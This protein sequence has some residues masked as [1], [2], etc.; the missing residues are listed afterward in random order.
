VKDAVGATKSYSI[1]AVYTNYTNAAT[2]SAKA[3]YRNEVA[4]VYLQ[5]IDAR[6]FEFRTLMSSES[7]EAAL[8]FDISALAV[9]GLGALAEKSAQELAVLSGFVVGAQSSVD[10]NL[11]FDQSVPAL[12]AAMDAE[13]LKVRS[14]I[15]RKLAQKAFDYPLSAVFADLVEYQ[16]A[17]T[18]ERAV[19]IVTDEAVKR[20]VAAEQ[21]YDDKV[22]FAC[23]PEQVRALTP[24]ETR[25]LGDFNFAIYEAAQEELDS[26]GNSVL[27]RDR[28]EALARAYGIRIPDGIERVRSQ[29]DIESIDDLVQMAMLED[30]CTT[31]DV[32]A[33]IT[34]LNSDPAF[35]S[36]ASILN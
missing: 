27:A 16:A 8:A 14:G 6:Y 22:R 21:E 7:R 18:L 12:V 35:T 25:K 1:P 4:Y 9:A 28:L 31:A 34:K 10:K 3:A 24:G 32:S 23:T 33:Q 2:D 13:R 5:A 20:R 19:S 30:F 29:L 11:Y 15:N 36:F 26:G 17:G